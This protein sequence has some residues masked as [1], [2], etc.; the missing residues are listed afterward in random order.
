[1]QY[2]VNSILNTV[3]CVTIL[4]S[5]PTFSEKNDQN[6][7]MVEEPLIKVRIISQFVFFLNKFDLFIHEK[8]T[9]FLSQSEVLYELRYP[10][11]LL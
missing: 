9:L 10:K 2:K 6:V 4:K 5:H 8:V 3:C 7:I 1:M 11:A